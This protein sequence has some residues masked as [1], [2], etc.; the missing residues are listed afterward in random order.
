MEKFKKYADVA[1]E[2]IAYY[3][4]NEDPGQFLNNV[5]PL[6][7]EEDNKVFN[8]WWLAHLVDVRLDAYLRTGQER[9]LE[10]AEMTYHYNKHR[11][12]DTLIHEYY[13]DMLWNALAA[14]RLYEETSKGEYLRDAE[15]VCRDIFDTAWN[16]SAGGGFAWKRTQ[17]Y[18]KNTPVNAPIM[19]LALHLYQITEETDLLKI[20]KRT[21]AWMKETLVNPE[22]KFVEDGINRNEDGKVDYDWKFTYNQGIYIGALVEFFNVTKNHSYLDEAVQCAKTSLDVLVKDGVFNDEGDGGDIGLFK[23]ILYRYLVLLYKKTGLAF[24]SEFIES[25]CTILL[26]NCMKPE[27]HLLV[28]RDWT[29]TEEPMAV[30][31]ADQLSGVMALE[32]AS[33]IE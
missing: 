15:E 11:N 10:Q 32:A 25:S 14:L 28:Y 8:Y 16:D 2:S 30:F 1:Q 27:G 6:S 7:S 23:G 13:D 21:L 18:Y 3:Y 22:T 20:C 24:I 12:H 5:Y 17:I 29:I 9:Y 31:L 26:D 4:H 19:I 33:V